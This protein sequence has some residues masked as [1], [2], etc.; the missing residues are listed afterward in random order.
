M[1]GS[2]D[3]P[4]GTDVA[5]TVKPKVGGLPVSQNVTLASCTSGACNAATSF[6]LAAGALATSGD[7]ERYFDLDGKRYCHILDPRTGMP[8]THWQSISVAAPL[9]VVGLNPSPRRTAWTS[10]CRNC[11]KA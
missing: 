2:H 8:V 5:V 3:V 6:D 1:E 10:R 4:A 9:C 7:Y 11:R